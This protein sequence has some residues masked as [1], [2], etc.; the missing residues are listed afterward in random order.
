MH[1]V[2][3]IMVRGSIAIPVEVVDEHLNQIHGSCAEGG[4]STEV[5][6]K[7]VHCSVACCQGVQCVLQWSVM[8][9]DRVGL[10]RDDVLATELVVV[11]NGVP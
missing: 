3:L 11:L 10:L 1:P 6:V 2:Q 9:G 4:K 5:A 8:V 7:P